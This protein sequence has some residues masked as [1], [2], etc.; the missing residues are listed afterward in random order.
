MLYAPVYCS[1]K[2][3]TYTYTQKNIYCISEYCDTSADNNVSMLPISEV[4]VT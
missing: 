2:W 3:N 1:E 4:K